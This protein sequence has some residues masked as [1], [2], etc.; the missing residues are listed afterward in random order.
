MRE[1]HHADEGRRREKGPFV[2]ALS[3][4]TVHGDVRFRKHPKTEE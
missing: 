4:T 3:T 2:G 1:P